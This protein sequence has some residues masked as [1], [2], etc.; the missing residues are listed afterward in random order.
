MPCDPGDNS[1]NPIIGPPPQIPGFGSPFSPIQI[2]LPDFDLPTEL[3]EDLLDLMQELGALFPS[4]LFKANTDGFMKNVLDFIANILS[5]LA[6]FLSFYNFIMALLN[7][8]ICIIE[9]LCAIPNPFAVA[10]KLVK[11]FQECLPPF[12]NLFPWLA[13]IAMILALLLL[14]LALILFLIETIL[15]IIRELIENILAFGRAVEL[16]DAQATLAIAQKIASLLCF[17]ENLMAIFIAIA[18]ILAIIQALAAFAG[19]GICDDED[20]E[21]CCPP[22]ICPPFLKNNREIDVPSGQLEY[23]SQ[24][25]V[26]LTGALPPPLDTLL[27]GLVSPIREERWQIFSDEVAP[28]TPINLIITPTVASFF[29]GTEQFYPDQE[30]LATTPPNRAPYTVDIRVTFDPAT[31]FTPPG[32]A[33]HPTDTGGEREFFIKDCIALRVPRTFAFSFVNTPVITTFTAN[34]VFDVEGGLVFEADEET[35]FIVDGY[36]ATLNNFIHFPDSSATT[37]PLVSDTAVFS[38]VSFVWKPQHPVLA[39]N[40]LITVGCIPEVSVEKAVAN[41]ILFTEGVEAVVDRLQPAPDGEVVPSTGSFLPNVLGA[42]QC[43]LD[44]VAELRQDV[45]VVTLT[46]FQSKVETCLGDLQDQT[47]AVFCDAF[48]QAVSQFQSTFTIDTDAQF[49]SR[50]IRVEVTLKDGAGTVISTDIPE[51]CLPQILEKLKAQVTF[52][53]I[54]DFE[55]DGSLLFTAEIFSD[56]AGDGVLTVSFDG[57]IFSTITPGTAFDVP[58]SITTNEVNYTFVD[59]VTDKDVRRDQGD[60]AGSGD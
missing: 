60:V 49:V 17:I 45:S 23:N 55:Y 10:S 24:I 32:L 47:T 11:L 53:S 1:L 29:G 25:G 36:Q 19:T 20:G 12:L 21:G 42:Q 48:I 22:E 52:G 8:I 13:L 30:Y 9:V 15:A 7:L 41:S 39:G 43:V 27:A 6:P 40:D 18:A 2:P 54:T 58:T 38:D 31:V 51:D 14:I 5:Q 4:G 57:N 56:A 33:M 34:G 35:P 28:E 46:E 16:Q 44:A 3:L 59:A 26:D 50:V 37:L